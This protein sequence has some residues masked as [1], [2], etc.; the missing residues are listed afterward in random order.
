MSHNIMAFLPLTFKSNLVFDHRDVLPHFIDFPLGYGKTKLT[1][2]FCQCDPDAVQ[3]EVLNV[4]SLCQNQASVEI[5]DG[6]Y[7]LNQLS[8][9][10]R[11]AQSGWINQGEIFE[12]VVSI[13]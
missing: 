6:N 7:L 8:R 9:R 4:Q 3:G 10:R 5:A 11:E 2:E 13:D 12:E 1:F